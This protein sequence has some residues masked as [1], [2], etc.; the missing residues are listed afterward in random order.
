MCKID[1]RK[2]K[3]SCRRSCE[4]EIEKRRETDKKIYVINITLV[5][6]QILFPIDNG[7]V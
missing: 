1:G 4:E 6:S 3:K 2:T 7:R 5:F